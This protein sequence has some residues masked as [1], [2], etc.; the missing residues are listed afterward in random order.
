MLPLFF[1]FLDGAF[2]YDCAACGQACC[3]GKGVALEADRELVPLLRRAPALAPFLEPLPG[4]YVRLPDVTDGC[5]FLRGD[6]MCAYE[7]EHGRAAKFTTC[8]LFPFNR[9][10]RAGPVR[11]VDV[12]SVV[13][14]VQDA[15]GT[16]QG[17]SHDELARDLAE[18][19]DG[20]LTSNTAEPPEGAQ[21]LRWHV[22]E[23][24]VLAESARFLDGGLADYLGFAA[25]Q[26]D[27]ARRHVG[28]RAGGEAESEA[29]LRALVATWTELYG[30]PDPAQQAAAARAVALLTPSLRFN[31]LFRRG[32]DGYRVA[33]VRTVRQLLATWFLSAA[34]ARVT[35]RVPSLRGL[36]ELHQ[37]QAGAR[38]LL[39]RLGEPAT[40]KTRLVAPDVPEPLQ[41]ALRALSDRLGPRSGVRPPLGAHLLAVAAPL[42]VEQRPLL[43]PLL[44]RAGP[45]LVLG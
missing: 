36:T 7:I 45:Q 5:W 1:T 37:A 23:E 40:L 38:A 41:A 31:A 29:S 4:G 44:L 22:L 14:P 15:L 6:G 25:W 33:A 24:R 16:G 18:L 11:V 21:A 10:F 17:V 20:P 3:R 42:P 32:G 2:R 28:E 34:A 12:N 9:V 39:A 13:C 35:G 8:R 43:V 30:A 19:G 27:T 26:D